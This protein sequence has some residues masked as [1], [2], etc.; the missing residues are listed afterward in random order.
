MTKEKADKHQ[1]NF[2]SNHECDYPTYL[3]KGRAFL[4]EIEPITN[5]FGV[6]SCIVEYIPI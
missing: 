4:R 5:L 6:C 2:I 1:A 3:A